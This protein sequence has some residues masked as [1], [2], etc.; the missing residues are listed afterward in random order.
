MER[1]EVDATLGYSKFIKSA[2][3]SIIGGLAISGLAIV[4][5]GCSESE[6][7]QSST[8][9]VKVE[10]KTP[11][12]AET[13]QV[14]TITPT[15]EGQIVPSP[16]PEIPAQIDCA[17]QD[18]PISDNPIFSADGTVVTNQIAVRFKEITNQEVSILEDKN[19]CVFENDRLVG[20]ILPNLVQA[21]NPATLVSLKN[22]L[23]NSINVVSVE[24][25]HGGGVQK[26][27]K[28]SSCNKQI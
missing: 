9:T 1:P 14:T 23:L 20:N 8:P 7:A 12:P 24:D 21:E 4:S 11:K 26:D 25:V 16:G 5:S 6:E 3:F 17:K 2:K 10:T 28:I 19:A 15:P 18:P 27:E 13:F 22:E